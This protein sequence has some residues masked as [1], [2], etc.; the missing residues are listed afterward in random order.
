[1][2]LWPMSDRA[3]SASGAAALIALAL[4]LA[5]AGCQ[6]IS[7]DAPCDRVTFI[8]RPDGS[9]YAACTTVLSDNATH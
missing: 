1:M 2:T 7:W 6:M 8:E 5:L 3:I 9:E 4:S